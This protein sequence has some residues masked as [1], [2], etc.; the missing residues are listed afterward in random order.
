MKE[1]NTTPILEAVDI[2]N[3]GNGGNLV[4]NLGR[5]IAPPYY[6]FQKERIAQ[7]HRVRDIIRKKIENIPNET[8]E[9]KKEM[10]KKYDKFS[11]DKI[12]DMLQDLIDSE[13]VTKEE[14]KYLKRLIQTLTDMNKVEYQYRKMME[15]YLETEIMWTGW[16]KG[17]HGIG[18]VLATN[19]IFAYGE[20][21][22]KIYKKIVI[23]S[24]K[25]G[26]EDSIELEL[27]A[28]ESEYPAFL[29]ALKQYNADPK[30]FVYKG[31]NRV[32]AMNSHSGMTPKGA[33]GRRRGTN[34]EKGVALEYSPKL[35][36]LAWK[37]G[38]SFIKKRTSPYRERY[39]RQKQYEINLM[40]THGKGVKIFVDDAKTIQ[41]TTCKNKM[42]VELRSKRVAVKL[43]LQHYYLVGRMLRG[44]R[45]TKP[46]AFN[47]LGH[48]WGH[49]IYPPNIPENT[50]E[51]YLGNS[52]NILPVNELENI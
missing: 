33:I 35:K 14:G 37:A 18:P 22:R 39:D 2:P 48:S 38:E 25:E 3:N 1:K 23:P 44:L 20:T 52:D 27:V 5:L 28:V 31:Y 40:E 30:A 9:K 12:P 49:F 15:Q 51:E 13:K 8:P 45:V 41:K 42:Q 36:V 29:E 19:L 24:K 50:V 16:L 43:F 17:L 10:L 32:E 26:E 4:H 46:Y 11:D 21:E 7:S 6:S 34:G 47:K